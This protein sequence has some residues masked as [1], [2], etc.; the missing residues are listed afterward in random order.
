MIPAI[1]T[2]H[3]SLCFLFEL[4]DERKSGGRRTRKEAIVVEG[5]A[6]SMDISRVALYM[7]LSESREQEKSLK[8]EMKK[9][10]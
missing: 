10:V 3:K 7:A 9:H 1:Y 6:G 5:L 2:G 4:Q 8:N